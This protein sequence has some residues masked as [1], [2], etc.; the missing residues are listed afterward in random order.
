MRSRRRCSMCPAIHINSRSW[1]RSS[2]THEPSDP[3]L[4][5][6][7]TFSRSARRGNC[8][9]AKTVGRGA[10]TAARLPPYLLRQ[11]TRAKENKMRQG[12]QNS[13]LNRRGVR[14]GRRESPRTHKLSPGQGTGTP[15]ATKR[16][17]SSGTAGRRGGQ[18]APFQTVARAGDVSPARTLGYPAGL[19]NRPQI[20][21]FT[22]DSGTGPGVHRPR[23]PRPWTTERNHR[24]TLFVLTIMILPQV[25]LRKPCYDFYFL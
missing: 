4:R 20:F 1:L 3:P 2:S 9:L 17:E 5:V 19:R 23:K 12:R 14:G 8:E 7:P 16:D 13:S 11:T 6:M 18:N 25:H 21:R 15:D 10:A 24:Q 22:W